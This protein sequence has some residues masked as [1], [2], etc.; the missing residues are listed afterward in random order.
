MGLP[1]TRKTSFC[2]L[3]M[4]KGTQKV[5]SGD[6]QMIFIKKSSPSAPD[7]ESKWKEINIEELMKIIDEL[8]RYKANSLHAKN[9]KKQGIMNDG[10]KWE[11]LVLLDYNVLSSALTLL[12]PSVVTFV[13]YKMLGSDFSFSDPCN[14]IK[15]ENKF[16]KFVKE[17]LACS[18]I[19]RESKFNELK[20]SEECG[21]CR[22]SYTV[23]VGILNGSSSSEC[24]E[25][26]K[27]V[28]NRS[29][30]IVKKHIN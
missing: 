6:T 30:H 4:G 5:S 28:I 3:L 21:D 26:E 17:L 11:V 25:K 29:L 27:D 12:Q 14:F 8:S 19:T 7:K 23:F 24:Y 20:I 22:T 18:C 2:N 15:N 10:E 9:N 1:K 16:T 13:A